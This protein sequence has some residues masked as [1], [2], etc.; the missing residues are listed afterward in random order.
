MVINTF[1]DLENAF[2]EA[3]DWAVSADDILDNES[4]ITLS[5]IVQ[6]W[7]EE[8]FTNVRDMLSDYHGLSNI[9][10]QILK[11]ICS[12]DL[13]LA[14]EVHNN[15]VRD[16]CVREM[17]CDAVMKFI[18]CARW[19]CYGDTPEYKQQFEKKLIQRCAKF[20]I[21]INKV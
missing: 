6:N 17:F 16:T 8:K 18:G 20:K 14:L 3:L 7:P 5:C 11:D 10:C 19:P 21:T 9:K 15:G 12:N 2:E 13:N 4:K 1:D